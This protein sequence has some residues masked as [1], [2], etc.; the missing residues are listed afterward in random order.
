MLKS[1]MLKVAVRLR[2]S[3]QQ[4]CIILNAKQALIAA[5]TM[6][7]SPWLFAN[8]IPSLQ[9][10]EPW[11]PMI[12]NARCLFQAGLTTNQRPSVTKAQ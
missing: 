5:L 8:N 9:V 3:D 6:T 1:T 7:P 12:A 2:Q 11:R 4:K 10:A